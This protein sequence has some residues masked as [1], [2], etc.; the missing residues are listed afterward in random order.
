MQLFQTTT[1][2]LKS[3]FLTGKEI[4][5]DA[6]DVDFDF[7]DADMKVTDLDIDPWQAYFIT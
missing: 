7:E 6:S 1:G 5:L 4:R 3:G 2:F